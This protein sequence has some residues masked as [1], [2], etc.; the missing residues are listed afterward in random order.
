MSRSI[1]SDIGAWFLK[2]LYFIFFWFLLILILVS[3]P[4]AKALGFLL[5]RPNL[6]Q[7]VYHWRRGSCLH[8]REFPLVSVAVLYFN[9]VYLDLSSS[10]IPSTILPPALTSLS[11]TNPQQGQT[12]TRIDKS[13]STKV[14]QLLHFCVVL[15]LA[16]YVKSAIHDRNLSLRGLQT[17]LHR[18]DHASTP[19][20]SV[21]FQL[22]QFVLR[23][24]LSSQS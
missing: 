20:W 12:C 6:R 10:L 9:N 23:T 24:G 18:R 1:N 15:R 5:Q 4:K 16:T 8:R 21:Y 7:H 17:I 13:F 19:P 3:A 11:Q 2:I 22:L 14:P